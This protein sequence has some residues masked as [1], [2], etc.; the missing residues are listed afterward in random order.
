MWSKFDRA[1]DREKTLVEHERLLDAL[2][3]RDRARCVAEL[4]QHRMSGRAVVPLL[5]SEEA[6]SVNAPAA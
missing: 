2:A 3:A 5:G 6:L 1:Q 4:E